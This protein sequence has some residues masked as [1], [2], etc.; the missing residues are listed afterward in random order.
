MARDG[1]QNDSLYFI[2]SCYSSDTYFS[3]V[4]QEQEQEREDQDEWNSV[5]FSIY[6]R[7]EERFD[8]FFISSLLLG[9][10]ARVFF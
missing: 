10:L 6:G 8:F 2:Q 5:I 9:S 1:A 3:I 7:M 4:D